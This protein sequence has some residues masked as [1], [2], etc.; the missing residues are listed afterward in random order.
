MVHVVSHHLLML[1][2]LTGHISRVYNCFTTQCDLAY[3]GFPN[4]FTKG[5]YELVACS[6]QRDRGKQHLNLLCVL[7]L[8]KLL[9]LAVL[10]IPSFTQSY[11]LCFLQI[12]TCHMLCT[13]S[14]HAIASC[15]C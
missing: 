4:H 3:L 2:V 12:H 7:L 5:A 13:F 15:R 11:C 9:D 10:W 14:L 6:G 8:S 1:V